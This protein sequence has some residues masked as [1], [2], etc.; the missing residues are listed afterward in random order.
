MVHRPNPVQ[1]IQ[2]QPQQFGQQRYQPLQMGAA[3]QPL[4]DPAAAI[5][6]QVQELALEIYARLVAG[7]HL[8]PSYTTALDQS[9]LRQ[10]AKDSQAAATAYFSQLGVQFE[11][12]PN[13]PGS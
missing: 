5:Q 7:R 4:A 8:D 13:Q 11:D 10:L 1:S 9:H 2:Q 3:Q 12:H 6:G